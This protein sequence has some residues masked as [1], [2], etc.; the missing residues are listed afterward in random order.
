VKSSRLKVSELAAE[1]PVPERDAPW[2]PGKLCG[3][4]WVRPDGG[5][6]SVQW[7]DLEDAEDMRLDA[8]ER[9]YFRWVPRLSAGMV[10]LRQAGTRLTLG[11]E[12]FHWP[13]VIRLA[14]V[15]ETEEL[16]ERDIEGGFLAHPGGLLGFELRR[17][18]EGRRLV[19]AVRRLE[20]RLPRWLYF[21]VQA[22]LHE[23]STF[24]FLRQARRAL[25]EAR[26]GGD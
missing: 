19:V 4:T 20:P 23:R 21:L 7:V 8:I 6:D 17:R 25:E 2:Q 11:I 3:G 12:P 15:R 9:E 14:A 1:V 10:R 26:D 18:E 24:A 13:R 5:I 22:P 16:R